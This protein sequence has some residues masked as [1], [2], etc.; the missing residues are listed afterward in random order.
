MYVI[1]CLIQKV[2]ANQLMLLFIKTY[3]HVQL[4][5]LNLYSAVLLFVH[6]QCRG[7]SETDP[8]LIL[9]HIELFNDCVPTELTNCCSFFPI[10][11]LNRN[12]FNE[13]LLKCMR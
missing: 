10:Q 3:S 4:A 6:V 2:A 7:H 12:S 8:S 9:N 11:T 5:S 13:I 1:H